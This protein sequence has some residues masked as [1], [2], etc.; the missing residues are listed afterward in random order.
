MPELN[1]NATFPAADEKPAY[2]NVMFARIAPTYDLM[3]RLMTMGQDMASDHFS[4]FMRDRSVSP[5]PKT[6]SR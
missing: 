2:V 6:V 5:R 1:T 4:A 3:N